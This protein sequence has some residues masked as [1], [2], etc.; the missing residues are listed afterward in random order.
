MDTFC[1]VEAIAQATSGVSLTMFPVR[2]KGGRCFQKDHSSKT[3]RTPEHFFVQTQSIG[4][5]NRLPVKG[6]TL[7]GPM[8]TFNFDFHHSSHG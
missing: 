1:P 6:T 8:P 5:G 3:L 7:S 2:L 4:D